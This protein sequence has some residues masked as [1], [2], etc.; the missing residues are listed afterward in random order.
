MEALAE[1]EHVIEKGR[2]DGPRLIA[3]HTRDAVEALEAGVAAAGTGVATAWSDAMDRW[4]PKPSRGAT[5]IR[6]II[7]S[8]VL[9]VLATAAAIAIQ[10]LWEQAQRRREEDAAGATGSSGARSVVAVPVAEGDEDASEGEGMDAVE[11]AAF[12][13]RAL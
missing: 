11:E 5:A 7:L 8:V 4:R 1:I 13:A 6:L 12:R 3:E 10:R 9:S 2:Q